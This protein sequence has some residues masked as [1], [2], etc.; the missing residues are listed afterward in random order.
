M[1]PLLWVLYFALQCAWMLN[2]TSL[3]ICLWYTL[4]LSRIHNSCSDRLAHS[5]TIGYGP[6]N[7]SGIHR[8]SFWPANFHRGSSVFQGGQ[9]I[10]AKYPMSRMRLGFFPMWKSYILNSF[11]IVLVWKHCSFLDLW[12]L[13]MI[14]SKEIWL[15]NC[16]SSTKSIIHQIGYEVK[17]CWQYMDFT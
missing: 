2:L 6:K 11:L 14:C 10:S 4:G 15:L 3:W 7:A 9:L 16:N 5:G 12:A 13:D 17:K 1:S 8:R